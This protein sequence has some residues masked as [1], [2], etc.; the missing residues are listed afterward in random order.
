MSS[1]ALHE[2]FDH[3]GYYSENVEQAFV[4]FSELGFTTAP[5]SLFVEQPFA[6]CAIVIGDAYLS[7]SGVQDWS[8]A[9]EWMKIGMGKGLQAFVL[10]S[11]N[12][13][14]VYEQIGPYGNDTL[15]L[16]GKVE[17][18][19]RKLRI[20]DNEEIVRFR[21][22][23]LKRASFPG[24]S[25][26]NYCEH[27]SPELLWRPEMLKHANGAVAIR[28]VVAVHEAPEFAAKFYRELFKTVTVTNDGDLLVDCR[29]TKLRLVTRAR[30]NAIWP[31]GLA[32]VGQPGDPLLA[33]TRIATT[34]LRAARDV[35]SRSGVAF[36]ETSSGGIAVASDDAF[37]AVIEFIPNHPV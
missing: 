26:C 1:F 6:T 7:I 5:P 35:L 12:L 24:L 33:G 31:N 16:D 3:V 20:N 30:L 21:V 18:I 9:P 17:T 36:L 15:Q 19:G 2:G 37:G 4:R 10:R 32:P 34:D 22:L 14:A 13:P 11:Q 28:E 29:T 27:L 23:R 25:R 8:A